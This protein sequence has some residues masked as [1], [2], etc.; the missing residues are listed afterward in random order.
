MRVRARRPPARPSGLNAASAFL[1]VLR[2]KKPSFAYL[3]LLL[4]LF[5]SAFHQ[6][7]RAGKLGYRLHSDCFIQLL[8][9][10]VSLLPSL[11]P[12]VS[13]PSPKLIKRFRRKNFPL[14]SAHLNI[15]P[16]TTRAG[17][18]ASC[19]YSDDAIDVR[20]AAQ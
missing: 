5:L 17:E 8:P 13:F 3:V 11:S 16:L 14:I 10:K 1:F 9:P 18:R 19:I 6:D 15:A 7:S 4:L 20:R 12:S 2:P